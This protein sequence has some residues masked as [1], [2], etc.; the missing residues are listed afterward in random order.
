MTTPKKTV[1]PT[2]SLAKFLIE[3]GPLMVFFLA[4][5][6]SEALRGLV[7]P[8]LDGTGLVLPQVFSEKP[9]FLATLLF[10]LAMGVSLILS[11]VWLRHVPVMPLVSGAMVL[12]FGG[13]T[14]YFAD[15]TF[16][17][18]KPT[19]VNFLFGSALLIGLL[20]GKPLL[21]I[22]LDT[23]LELDDAGWHSLSL[24]W[25]LFFYVLAGLNELVWRT[26]TDAV[27]INF[28]V[29]GIMP[30]TFVFALSQTSLITRHQIQD[31]QESEAHASESNKPEGQSVR[32]GRG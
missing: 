7:L 1:S 12:L 16:I 20:F 32:D 30:L 21:K 13:L 10:M 2:R 14:L 18:I 31:V 5:S 29:F 27:W 4:N 11:L 3:L 23:M 22:V 17:K 8:L 19:A 26:Q 6:R 28:K 9:I 15:D 25:G 24:R